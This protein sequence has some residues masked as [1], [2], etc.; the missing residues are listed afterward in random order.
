MLFV[1]IFRQSRSFLAMNFFAVCLS[2]SARERERGGG[3]GSFTIENTP[4]NDSFDD[5]NRKTEKIYIMSRGEKER[6]YQNM[7]AAASIVGFINL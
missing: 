7:R 5:S 2:H 1:Y 6:M 4:E 3:R